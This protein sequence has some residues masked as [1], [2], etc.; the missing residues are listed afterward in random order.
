MGLFT[1]KPGG[2]KFGNIL[3]GAA[4]IGQRIAGVDLGIGSGKNMIPLPDTSTSPVAPV[5][6]SPVAPVST[7]PVAPAGGGLLSLADDIRG[8]L[9][10]ANQT[11][12][13]GLKID[14]GSSGK[15]ILYAAGAAALVG[16]VLF[17]LKK[18]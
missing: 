13:N 9:K 10:G 15:T 4:K 14:S 18:K 2:T 1:R 11:L 7:S 6:T 16:L 3:R 17:G 8:V 5:N 12:N